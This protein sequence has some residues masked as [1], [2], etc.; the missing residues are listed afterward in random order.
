[1]TGSLEFT[2]ERIFTISSVIQISSISSIN[3]IRLRFNLWKPGM[4]SHVSVFV[5]DH[6]SF[7]DGQ[8]LFLT[9]AII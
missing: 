7:V 6:C 1:M 5:I 2:H 3:S 9:D 8:D 4:T